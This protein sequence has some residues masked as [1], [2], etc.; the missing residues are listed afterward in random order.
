MTRYGR[1]KKQKFEYISDIKPKRRL[2]QV[3]AN[4]GVAGILILVSI[5]FPQDRWYLVYGAVIASVTSDTWSTEIGLLSHSEPRSI[6]NGRKVPHGTSGGL[7]PKGIAAGFAGCVCIFLSMT[8]WFRFHFQSFYIIC[9]SG[10]VANLFDSLLGATLQVRY[11][12]PVCHHIT[13]RPRHCDNIPTEYYEG[14]R[15]LTNDGVNFCASICGA[16]S[17]FLLLMVFS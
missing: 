6:H 9:G 7:T 12:C 10:L 13:E 2:H 15:L 3:I 11:H 14:I 4:G 8:P 5:F 16:V 1:E 17:A